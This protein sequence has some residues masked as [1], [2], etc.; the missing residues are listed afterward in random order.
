DCPNITSGTVDA[1]FRTY[2]GREGYVNPADLSR[3][4]CE[5]VGEWKELGR[6]LGLKD[7]QLTSIDE[8][9][10]KVGEKSYQMLNN[11]AKCNPRQATLENLK[12]ALE[13]MTVGRADLAER[14]C[15]VDNGGRNAIK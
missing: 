14:Y 2:K 8:N 12:R 1:V 11:W 5:V 3:L 15:N 6:A 13:D 7:W 10:P 9:N 4:A